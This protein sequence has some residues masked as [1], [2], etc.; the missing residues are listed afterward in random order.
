MRNSAAVDVDV[1]GVRCADKSHGFAFGGVE[2]LAPLNRPGGDAIDFRLGSCLSRGE[3]G[4]LTADS[5]IVGVR[6]G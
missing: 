2:F 5:K 4:A 6:V 3:V 1:Q